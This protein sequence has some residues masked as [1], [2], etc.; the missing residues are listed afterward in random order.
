MRAPLRVLR[1]PELR[2]VKLADF[3]RDLDGR[4]VR[5]EARD[6]LDAALSLEQV[7]EEGVSVMAE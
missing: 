1:L 2:D 3:T 7:V 6:G 4:K 5:V